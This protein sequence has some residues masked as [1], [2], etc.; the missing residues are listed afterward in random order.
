MGGVGVGGHKQPS[1]RSLGT[2]VMSIHNVFMDQHI[3][4]LLVL[5]R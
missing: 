5:L 1:P 3:R 4:G 2:V